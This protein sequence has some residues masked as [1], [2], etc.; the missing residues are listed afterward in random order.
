MCRVPGCHRG[1]PVGEGRAERGNRA[2]A[3]FR[4]FPLV[5]RWSDELSAVRFHL[6]P[7]WCPTVRGKVAF[8]SVAAVCP[9]ELA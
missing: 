7:R 2:A 6:Y 8:L 3:A 4:F 5:P 9:G 1:R